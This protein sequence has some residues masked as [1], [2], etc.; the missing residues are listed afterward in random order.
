MDRRLEDSIGQ[1]LTTT[2]VCSFLLATG[3]GLAGASAGQGEALCL[4]GIGVSLVS[5]VFWTGYHLRI[6]GGVVKGIAYRFLFS[7]HVTG[8]FGAYP[9]PVAPPRALTVGRRLRTRLVVFGV[10]CFLAGRPAAAS[11]ARSIHPL[12]GF[13]VAA[14]TL[15]GTS[16]LDLGLY[17][18]SSSD[19]PDRVPHGVTCSTT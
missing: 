2:F 10:A 14:L 15:G 5:G 7:A 16:L 12:F 18:P 4:L 9:P 6:S 8:W 19:P 13:V 17:L 1:V 3:L 11:C